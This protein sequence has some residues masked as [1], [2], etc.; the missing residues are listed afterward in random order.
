MTATY[1]GPRNDRTSPRQDEFPAC[2][3]LTTTAAI[4]T[5]VPWGT[6]SACD[7]W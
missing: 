3:E 2:H 5:T 4:G 6:G 7:R 1:T